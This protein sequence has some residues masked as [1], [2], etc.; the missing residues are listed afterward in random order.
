MFMYKRIPNNS[1]T[2]LDIINAIGPVIRAVQIAGQD[3]VNTE[4]ELTSEQVLQ[5]EQ[6]W[7]A[8]SEMEVI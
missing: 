4:V 2:D 5:L 6:L 3:S 1:F 7:G 8:K